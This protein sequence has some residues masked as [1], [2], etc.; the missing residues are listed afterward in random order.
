[1]YPTV[2]LVL[3]KTQRSM[4]DIYPSNATKLTGLVVQVTETR[5]ATLGRLSLAGGAVHSM[6]DGEAES[7]DSRALPSQGGQEHGLEE[8]ICEVKESQLGSSGSSRIGNK[9]RII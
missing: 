3:V 1:M 9:A 7:Q 5:P 4:T 6:T 2:V 8:V